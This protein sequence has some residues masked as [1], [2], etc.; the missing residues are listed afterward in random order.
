MRAATQMRRDF[1]EFMIMPVGAPSI[2]EALRNG[3]G[4]IHKDGAGEPLGPDCEYDEL[5]RIEQ[6][7]GDEAVFGAKLKA[8]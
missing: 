8:G 3:A 4:V 5:L 2:C 7:L 6:E 1:Q